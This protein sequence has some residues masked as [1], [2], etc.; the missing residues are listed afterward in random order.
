MYSITIIFSN[1]RE[2][3]VEPCLKAISQGH[4]K[5]QIPHDI[6]AYIV[7]H[8]NNNLEELLKELN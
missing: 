6:T 7:I 5:T 2:K 8:V 1:P 3:N 4:V